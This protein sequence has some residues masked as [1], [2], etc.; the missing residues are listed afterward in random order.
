MKIKLSEIKPNPI[1]D[2]IYSSTDLTDLISSLKFNGQLEPISINKKN[3]IISGHRRYYSMKQLEWDEC[4]VIVNDY[5]SEIVGLV[6]HNR[7][8][9]KSVQDILN[10][11]KWLEKEYK[12]VIGSGK[13]TDWSG[14]GKQHT[15]LEVA[16]KIGIG[17]TKLKQIKSINNYD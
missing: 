17:T 5:K 2:Q 9:V 8:R 12:K 3:V 14:K 11:S 6:E 1:N 7:T 15:H 13:R 4:E 10:E 16:S